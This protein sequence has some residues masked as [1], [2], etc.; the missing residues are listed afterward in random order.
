MRIADIMT[1]TPVTVEPAMSLG[2]AAARMRERRVR[3]LL[4]VEAD[5]LLGLVTE[6][7]LRATL[8]SAEEA[9]ERAVSTCMRT[10]L[11]HIGSQAPVEEAATRMYRDKIGALPVVDD[12]HLV[13]IVTESDIF[14]SFTTMLGG[15]RGFLQ[16]TVSDS[17]HT[18][19]KIGR[20]LRLPSLRT[21]W[22]HPARPEVLL[23]FSTPRGL[24]DA[25]PILDEVRDCSQLTMAGWHLS[26]PIE[27]RL[28]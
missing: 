17:P 1:A 10:A 26:E 20:L 18:R 4:V 12:G 5:R 2:E 15:G 14:R 25:R 24:P 6:G 9:S 21:V 13:G 23:V 19:P 11:I 8:A 28:D 7:D 16:V 3:R 27:P 22:F